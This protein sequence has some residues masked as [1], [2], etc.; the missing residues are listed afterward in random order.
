LVGFANIKGTITNTN[1]ELAAS[2]ATRDVL[3][4]AT[5]VCE[6]TI[7]NV[8]ENLSTVWWQCTWAT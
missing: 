2:V 1:L 3:V 8:S 6:A 4:Q 7:H 5:D